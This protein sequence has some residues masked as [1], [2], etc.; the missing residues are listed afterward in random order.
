MIA[1]LLLITFVHANIL[2]T[3]TFSKYI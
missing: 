2:I 1:D 3:E